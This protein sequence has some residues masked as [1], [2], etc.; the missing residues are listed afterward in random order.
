MS[1]VSKNLQSFLLSSSRA[2]SRNMSTTAKPLKIYG[3]PLSQPVRS[4]LLLCQANN[5]KYDFVLVDALKG[6][7]LKP[8]FKAI[9]PAGL[10]PAIEEE[11]LGVLGECSAIMVYL[12]ESRKLTQWYPADPAVRARINFWMSWNHANTR[13]CTSG[14]LRNKMFPPRAGGG[15]ELI[16]AAQKTLKGSL[17]FMEIQ[18]QRTKFLAPGDKPTIAD[19]VILTELDQNSTEGFGFV[20]LTP[21]PAVLRW[22]GDVSSAVP[23]YQ[24]VF[25]P[26]KVMAAAAAARAAKK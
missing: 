10:L 5:I 11:G 6:Q 22:M 15:D 14:V 18:L 17:A 23:T 2:A 25:E 16:A 21:Y 7:N 24:T 4:V 12:A 13:V 26:V 9:H 8:E 19:L 3:F 1:T 20:D